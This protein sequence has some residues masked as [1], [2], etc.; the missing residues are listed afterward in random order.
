[1]PVPDA[2]GDA[3]TDRFDEL[4]D[5][6]VITHEGVLVAAGRL[7]VHSDPADM[8]D[9]DHFA[10]LAAGFPG[11]IALMSRLVVRRAARRQGLATRIDQA[12]IQAAHEGGAACIVT[13]C[14]PPRVPA[15]LRRGFVALRTRPGVRFPGVM[16]TVLRL[17]I[18]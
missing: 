17:M 14:S 9:A 3:W 8:P 13:E 15:L 1:M 11:P 10:E 18:E 2:T 16:W 7:T 5:H 6:F 12:R 4:A